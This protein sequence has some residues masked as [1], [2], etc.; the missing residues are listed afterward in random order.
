ME[1][2]SGAPLEI[3]ELGKMEE[4]QEVV[5]PYITQKGRQA[6]KQQGAFIRD[7]DGDMVTPLIDGKE[8]AYTVFDEGGVAK[9]GIEM[10]WKDG[11]TD[12]RKPISCHLYP[13][14][15]SVL[16]NGVHALNYH[17]WRIC[18]PA[19]VCGAQLNVKVYRFLKEALI[20]KYGEDFYLDLVETD[21]ILSDSNNLKS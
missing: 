5:M 1:G 4:V 18:D 2:D 7:E 8:C 12:F 21:R 17:R 9:C 6:I 14:R 11:K 19:R 10:A 3:N 15:I 16:S 20:R 13:I